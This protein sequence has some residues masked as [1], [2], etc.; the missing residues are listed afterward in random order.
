MSRALDAQT[1]GS[2]V[3]IAAFAAAEASAAYLSACPASG[4]AWYLNLAA[5]RPFEAARADASPLHVLFGIDALRNA[6]GLIAATLAFRVLKFR[7]G[8]AV[9]ANLCFVF[10]AALA[11]VWLGGRSAPQ[12]AALQPVAVIQGPDFAILAV[13]L[14]SSF[15]AFAISH[16]SFARRIRS[17]RH[18]PP[19]MPNVATE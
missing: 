17:E 9:I 1:F 13:M 3:V 19:P 16:M 4:F 2:I 12:T 5:F 15:L 18:G 11:Y 14:T 10:A 6:V 7:F 8:I